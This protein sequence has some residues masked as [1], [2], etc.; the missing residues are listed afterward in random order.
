MAANLIPTVFHQR[1]SI[2]AACSLLTG[3]AFA[4]PGELESDSLEILRSK[5]FHCHHEHGSAPFSLNSEAGLTA[6]LKAI[7]KAIADRSMPP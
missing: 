5:C 7:R 1:F 2:L 4:E 3:A 6:N